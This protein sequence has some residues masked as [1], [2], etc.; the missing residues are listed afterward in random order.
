MPISTNV[1]LD[2]GVLIHHPELVNLYGC[3]IG[4]DTKIGA[5]VEVQLGAEQILYPPCHTGRIPGLAMRLVVG[6]GV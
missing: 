3:R 4:Q 2:P 5:F 6:T 1:V